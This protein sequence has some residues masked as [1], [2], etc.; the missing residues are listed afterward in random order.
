MM[1]GVWCIPGPSQSGRFG[2]RPST[3]LKAHGVEQEF[4]TLAEAEAEAAR[5]NAGPFAA[6]A[7]YF[8][9]ERR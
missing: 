2:L 4:E 1:F 7:T 6:H 8:A 9:K 5:L 3:W